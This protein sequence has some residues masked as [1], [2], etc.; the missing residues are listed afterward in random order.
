MWGMQRAVWVFKRMPQLG[1]ATL[2]T[3]WKGSGFTEALDFHFLF[4]RQ[5]TVLA[6]LV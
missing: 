6:P 1:R 5:R 3:G 4:I 2:L